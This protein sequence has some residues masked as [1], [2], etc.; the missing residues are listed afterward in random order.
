MYGWFLFFCNAIAFLCILYLPGM[1][2][3]GAI[4]SKIDLLQIAIAPALSFALFSVTGL[5]LS[6]AGFFKAV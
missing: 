4:R 6:I 1:L 3:A 5:A 2:L